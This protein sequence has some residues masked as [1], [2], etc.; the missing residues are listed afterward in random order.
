MASMY[1]RLNTSDSIHVIANHN[2]SYVMNN[3]AA[4][5]SKIALDVSGNAVTGV[6]RVSETYV[7]VRWEWLMLTIALVAA[8][9]FMFLVTGLRTAQPHNNLWL[10]SLLTLF[11]HSFDVGHNGRAGS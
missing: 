1:P 5:L 7:L 6:V 8:G 9:L 2:L 11:Y 3:I 4:S 10:S